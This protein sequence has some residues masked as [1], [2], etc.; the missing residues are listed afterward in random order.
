[1]SPTTQR[2]FVSYSHR[3][4]KW[5][6]RL[7]V[8][9]APLLRQRPLDVWEDTRLEAG[10]EWRVEIQRAI[11]GAAVA[12]LL[13]SPDFLASDF[14]DKDELPPIL[15]RADAGKLR[16][17]WLA[18]SHSLYKKTAIA[19]YEALNDPDK[20]LSGL[21]T[22]AVDKILVAACE[23]IDKVTSAHVPPPPPPSR[24][25]TA[26]PAPARASE[27]EDLFWS[28]VDRYRKYALIEQ[29]QER[30]AADDALSR[31]NKFMSL[32]QLQEILDDAPGD[33]EIHMALAVVL[34]SWT[35]ADNQQLVAQMLRRLLRSPF[36]R[37]RFRAAY[38]IQRYDRTVKFRGDNR[39]DIAAALT[40]AMH[41]ER[42]P[43]VRDRIAATLT[44]LG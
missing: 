20:P 33:G 7:Q 42:A 14:I 16:I 39:S 36:E 18:V 28:T 4:E 43:I 31:S 41:R 13:V 44:G 3:D 1:M 30:V 32:P 25:A 35:S 6:R 12:V 2:L 15:A 21:K 23:A 26:T 8:H 29:N 27:A 38:A 10:D 24:S 11:Q 9:L 40:A 17:M 5:L 19:K 22:A 34:G 37:A